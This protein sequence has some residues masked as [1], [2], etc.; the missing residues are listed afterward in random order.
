MKLFFCNILWVLAVMTTHIPLEQTQA[1]YTLQL[2]KTNNQVEV[3]NFFKVDSGLILPTNAIVSSFYNHAGQLY[4]NRSDSSV[5]YN[6]GIAWI[7]ML[8]NILGF[9]RTQVDSDII[10]RGYITSAAIAGKVNYS[11]SNT[12]FATPKKLRDSINSV[13]GAIPTNNNQIANGA[14]Y[15]TVADISGKVNYSDSNTTFAT[16]KKLRDSAIS[17][18]S[19]IPTN[20]NQLPN[21]AGYIT[22]ITSGNVTTAL[23]YTPVTNARTITIAGT[24]FDLSAD[25][26]FSPT[27]TNIPEGLNLYYTDIRARAAVSLTTTGSGVAT[28]SAGVL[29]IPTPTN[30]V[31]AIHAVT[32]A[33]NST[34][35]TPSSTLQATVTYTIQVSCT[36][37]IGSNA[38]GQILL[39]YST[40]GGSS[41]TD[42]GM[43]K[44]SNT[45]S[46][47][48]AL[49]LVNIQV[50]SITAVVPVGGLC[51]MAPT[52]SGTTTITYISGFEVY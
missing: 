43:V 22:G 48:I 25:R 5:Y 7:K 24:T 38:S 27:T 13:R 12:T 30:Y 29:N 41:W 8:N 28:Y 14:A 51:R 45:V 34:T 3:L 26:T 35:F 17:V 39:Q 36:A 20:N 31:P 9:T 16:P 42:A 10:S 11:D 40:N 1:K 50:A 46:L 6:N 15:I 18:R 23:G 21:G 49:N 44:N 37:T 52:T 2:G 47:A 33:I 32:R 19:A 4:F